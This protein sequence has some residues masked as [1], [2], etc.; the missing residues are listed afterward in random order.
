MLLCCAIVGGIIGFLMAYFN[1]P[2]PEFKIVKAPGLYK[3]SLLP[4]VVLVSWLAIAIHELGH[5]LAGLS[6]GFEF[7]FISVGP[8]MLEK[9]GEKMK[10][11]WNTNF[12]NY[13]GLALCLPKRNHNLTKR[14][15]FF[16]VG[17]PMASLI[18]G[19][20][21]LAISQI[22]TLDT[23][24]FWGYLMDSFLF[25]SYFLSF[26]IFM[27]TIIPF[28][29]GNFYSD[30]ARI[31]NLLG[32]GFKAEVEATFLEHVA[33]TTA[34]VRPGLQEPKQ[35][36]A[37]ID[38]QDDHPMKPIFHV[39]LY[40][41]FLDINSLSEAEHH[42]KAYTAGADNFHEGY[43]A[44]IW[45]ENAWF[46]VR[47]YNNSVL[48]KEFFHREK[49]GVIISKSLILR[50]EAGIAY[51]EGHRDLA[52]SKAQAAISELGTAR[53]KGLA[54]AEKEWLESLIREAALQTT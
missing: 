9:E 41:H 44:N 12:N 10:F 34:G 26:I 19:L 29:S 45:L 24:L 38:H 14:F 4:I 39:V 36:Q 50:A 5:V 2:P 23:T 37:I 25:F 20:V 42:L 48:A 21:T 8:T 46:Q 49:F 31:K 28:R 52:I 33:N 16:A 1:Q 27:G 53:D 22:V 18:W 13:G 40:H 15:A 6:Q 30:G 35:V 7:R 17:G 43:R 11:K 51:A 3:L 47:V 32:G 54:V